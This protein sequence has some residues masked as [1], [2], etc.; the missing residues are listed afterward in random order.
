ME[1]ANGFTVASAV[2]A[3]WLEYLVQIL[4]FQ[5]KKGPVSACDG[6]SIEFHIGNICIVRSGVNVSWVCLSLACKSTRHASIGSEFWVVAPMFEPV[7]HIIV[8]WA[9]IMVLGSSIQCGICF[10]K[11]NAVSRTLCRTCSGTFPHIRC[12]FFGQT[13]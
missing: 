2:N 11:W 5:K 8:Y 12:A 10:A 4:L 1:H 3:A 13:L 6:M 9:A 7:C